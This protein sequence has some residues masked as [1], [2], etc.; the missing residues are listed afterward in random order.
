MGHLLGHASTNS[1]PARTSLGGSGLF[2][3][4]QRGR[5]LGR[6]LFMESRYSNGRSQKMTA[7]TSILVDRSLVPQITS[8]GILLEG[9]AQ[10]ITLKLSKN[11][12]LTIVNIYSARTSNERALMWKQLNEA[13]FD[14]SHVIIRRDFNHLEKTE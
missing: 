5:V 3:F 4:N 14:T 6:S 8:N 1:A 12:N 7:S 13:N 2:Y 10:Y 11:E 9:R